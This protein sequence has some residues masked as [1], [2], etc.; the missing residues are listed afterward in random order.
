M[1]VILAHTISGPIIP[2]AR[3]I[4]FPYFICCEMILLILFI[5]VAAILS[6]TLLLAIFLC[7]N[8]YACHNRHQNPLTREDW[9]S[10]RRRLIFSFQNIYFETREE[11]NVQVME[12]QPV[13]E[14]ENEP[15]NNEIQLSN[16]GRSPTLY[17]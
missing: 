10:S 13:F 7:C 6:S 8:L 9:F 12:H 14:G 5:F 1:S 4:F 17:S 3:E 2:L 16:S 15:G 11:G